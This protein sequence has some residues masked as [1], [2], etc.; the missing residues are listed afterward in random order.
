MNN[1]SYLFA[2]ILI[3][4]VV[5]LNVKQYLFFLIKRIGNDRNNADYLFAYLCSI[6]IVSIYF[7]KSN[8]INDE[9]TIFDKASL[10][11]SLI[12]LL[13][14]TTYYLK[15]RKKLK[16]STIQCFNPITSDLS[17]SAIIP[18]RVDVV[19]F[20]EVGLDRIDFEEVE[21][22]NIKHQKSGLGLMVEVEVGV[23]VKVGEA[24]IEIEN[25]DESILVPSKEQLLINQEN[26][27]LDCNESLTNIDDSAEN[28]SI[29]QPYFSNEVTP[30]IRKDLSK[31]EIEKIYEE[32]KKYINPA[33]HDDFRHLL[34]GKK[35]INKIQWTYKSKKNKLTF[36]PY[37]FKLFDGLI[38]DGLMNVMKY[39]CSYSSIG[40]LIC[41]HFNFN[42]EKNIAKRL[43]EWFYMSSKSNLIVNTE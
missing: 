14:L 15:F 29:S 28:T 3:I 11:I 16:S 37:L 24:K 33:S 17:T 7:I 18:D 4:V 39:D 21:L 42:S 1:I 38:E 30:K 2:V 23:R 9:L 19:A 36:S 6:F 32:Y 31:S 12:G 35:Q 5:F 13:I 40:K 20:K 22:E 34:S 43:G 10:Y 41:Q 25:V 26:V 8:L 27:I